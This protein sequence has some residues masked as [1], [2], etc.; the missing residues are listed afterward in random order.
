MAPPPTEAE[1]ELPFGYLDRK[2]GR[3]HRTGRLRLPTQRDLTVAIKLAGEVD[4]PAYL[5]TLLLSRILLELGNLVL[6]DA[7]RQE[8]IEAMVLPDIDH[9][10][11]VYQRLSK[12]S[13]QDSACPMCGRPSDGSPTAD[14]GKGAD[15]PAETRS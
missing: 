1:F 4:N 8:I 13:G 2:T 12:G 14:G 15:N 5:E 10:N 11:H 7:N 9:L 6:D 3:A